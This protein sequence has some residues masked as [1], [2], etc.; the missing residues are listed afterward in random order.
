MEE[1][2]SYLESSLLNKCMVF[3][4]GKNPILFL[5]APNH[6]KGTTVLE[7]RNL[8]TENLLGIWPRLFLWLLLF[9]KFFL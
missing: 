2:N 1:S 3:E 5:K 6:T 4:V 7:I 9:S 8:A